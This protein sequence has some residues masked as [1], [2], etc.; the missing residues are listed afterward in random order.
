MAQVVSMKKQLAMAKKRDKLIHYFRETAGDDASGLADA[1]HGKLALVPNDRGTS[2]LW[3]MVCREAQA[4]TIGEQELLD[5]I[6]D[7]AHGSGYAFPRA[8]I[9][10]YYVSLKTN[11]F[12]ILTGAQG[13]GK[14]EL[15][16]LFAQAL[17]GRDSPQYTLIPSAGVWPDATGEDSYYRSLHEQFSSWRFLDLLQEAALPS[18]ANKAYFVCFDALHPREL[19]YYF[20]T[21]LRVDSH[22]V[23]RLNLPGYPADR[24]FTIP[25]NVYISATVNI[26]EQTEYLSRN[27]LRHAGLIEFRAPQWSAES[28]RV[29]AAAPNV[30]PVG[31]QRIWLR[32]ALHDV[33]L[34]RARLVAIL[35]EDRYGRLRCSPKL[36]QLLWRTGLAL[37]NDILQELETYIANSFDSHNCG[38][39]DSNDAH[40]NAQIAYD[41]QVLQRFLW[42]LRDSPDQEV[43][44]DLAEYLD[45]VAFGT[46]QQAVA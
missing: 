33:S 40:H 4:A 22:G 20:A 37:T 13:R 41:S 7:V 8:L 46:V 16:R 39:F 27:V 38:L 17:V 34:A 5:H 43:R 35:G 21:L 29:V 28:S 10:N 45:L 23:K 14:T 30:P 12:V 24:Q 11:P 26:A 1:G 42:R 6:F 32:M 9:V 36:T 44:R 15:A 31:L 3:R 25:S 2:P 19:E 18:N